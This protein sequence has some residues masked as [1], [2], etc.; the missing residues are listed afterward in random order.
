MSARYITSDKE[1]QMALAD[2]V[3]VAYHA[4][5]CEDQEFVINGIDA[6]KHDFGVNRDIGSFD[7]DYGESDDENWACADNE[8]VAWEDIPEGVLEKYGITEAEYR[9]MQ[10]KL[11]A[12]FSVGHCGWCV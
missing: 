2:I 7:Y 4:L 9:E 5:P 8:F 1:N 3:I 11:E 12:K 10:S 6:D